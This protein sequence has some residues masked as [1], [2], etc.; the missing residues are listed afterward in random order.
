MEFLGIRLV[1]INSETG[2][3]LLL[4][5]AFV[6]AVLL[7]RKGSALLLVRLRG[8]DRRS[9]RS[10]FWGRQ[11]ISIT[12]ALVTL[13]ALVSIWFDDPQRLSTGLG[14]MSAGLAFA[15][16]RVITAGLPP[17]RVDLAARTH[18]PRI[19][20]PQDENRP[21]SSRSKVSPAGMWSPAVA[22]DTRQAPRIA[23]GQAVGNVV[24]PRQRVE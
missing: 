19:G 1:G 21:P 17:V 13:V 11:A 5:I 6:A 14:V 7:V 4:S 2:Y 8:A 3:K 23:S 12:F 18:E 15:L 24:A 16:Q 20:R 10:A 22:S 9:E